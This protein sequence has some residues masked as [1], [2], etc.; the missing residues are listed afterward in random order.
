[1]ENV[2]VAYNF[3]PFSSTYP[4]LIALMES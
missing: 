1:M 4:K 2:Y 3:S